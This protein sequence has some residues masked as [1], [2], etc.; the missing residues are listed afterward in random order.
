M[1]L[2]THILVVSCTDPTHKV[3]GSGYTSL[4]S[5]ASRS[6]EALGVIVSVRM[7]IEK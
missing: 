7:Q 4:I 3:R 2:V 6:T 1:V 5:W